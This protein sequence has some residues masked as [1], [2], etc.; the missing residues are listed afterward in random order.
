MV[1][2]SELPSHGDSWWN[3]GRSMR[4]AW[5]SSTIFMND[6]EFSWGFWARNIRS[7]FNGV[8]IATIDASWNS[9]IGTLSICAETI[10]FAV[11]SEFWFER[12]DMS[13]TQQRW[14]RAAFVA[15]D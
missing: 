2:R 13:V 8:S 3:Q 1:L 5:L 11:S 9:I 6:F 14:P 12:S 10:Q 7:R 4:L 15:N